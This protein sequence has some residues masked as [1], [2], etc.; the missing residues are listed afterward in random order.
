M[1]ALHNAGTLIASVPW[2]V[3]HHPQQSLVL[4][5]LR[6]AEVSATTVVD[7]AGSPVLTALRLG[8]WADAVRAETAV[9]VIVAEGSTQPGAHTVYQD[10]ISALQRSLAMRHIQLLGSHLVD[11]ISAGAPWVCADGCGAAGLVDDPSFTPFGIAGVVHGRHVYGTRAELENAVALSDPH[12]ST[13]ASLITATVGNGIADECDDETARYSV[14][15]VIAI[16]KRISQ[17]SSMRAPDYTQLSR[18]LSSERVRDLLLGLAVTAKANR[19]EHLWLTAARSMPQP[20]R[21]HSLVLLGFFAYA[22]G[23]QPLAEVSI[24]EALRADP[25]HNVAQTVQAALRR[26]RRPSFIW[27]LSEHSYQAA[28][29]SNIRLPR[30]VIHSRQLR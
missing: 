22:R 14:Q 30:H 4:I 15:C 5:T 10:L 18:I 3:S 7:L 21:T 12:A 28:Q 24:N 13:I 27:A 9:A 17:G 29:L 11:H 8:E 6:Q 2:L 19:V 26:N 16:A 20:F 23:D 1:S 25:Q